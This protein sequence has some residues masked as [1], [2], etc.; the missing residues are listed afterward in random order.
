MGFTVDRSKFDGVLTELVADVLEHFASNEAPQEVMNYVE[1]V[2]CPRLF[3][4]RSTDLKEAVW[5]SASTKIQRTA[6]CCAGF[7]FLKPAC[8]S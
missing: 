6:R 5:N 8:Q 4:L 1:K 3:I 2:R 7:L